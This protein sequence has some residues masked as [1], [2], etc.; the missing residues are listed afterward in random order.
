MTPSGTLTP[1]VAVSFCTLV[2]LLAATAGC[3]SRLPLGEVTGRVTFNGEP[4]TKGT[5]IFQA[6]YGPQAVGG[7]DEQGNYRLNMPTVGEGA[8]VGENVVSIMPPTDI[9]IIGMPEYPGA[10]PKVRF[11]N[12]PEKFRRPQTSGL[13]R[14]VKPGSNVFDFE[15][16]P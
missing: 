11:D 4:V 10:P 15:L 13:T 9:A 5:V 2:A 16:S 1:R 7:L 6:S 8:I 14:E 3:G 12:I